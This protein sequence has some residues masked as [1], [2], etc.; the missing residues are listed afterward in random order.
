MN[1]VAEPKSICVV[2]DVPGVSFMVAETFIWAAL[3]QRNLSRALREKD[4]LCQD[5]PCAQN[6][7]ATGKDSS[8][9]V[10]CLFTTFALFNV[11]NLK[12]G[13][14]AIIAELEALYLL[15]HSRIGWSDDREGIWRPAYPP[16][17]SEDFVFHIN[18]VK[19][20]VEALLKRL[21]QDGSAPSPGQ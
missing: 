2:I 18:L 21:P 8:S 15:P 9:A 11:T 6:G 7:F 16:G 1:T 13:L 19:A 12:G 5:V 17:S 14:A 3:I 20:Y 10:C 4:L